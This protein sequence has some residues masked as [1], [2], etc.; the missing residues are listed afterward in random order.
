LFSLCISL[1]VIL[2]NGGMDLSNYKVTWDQDFTT[3]TSLS[4]TAW[5]PGSTWIAHTPYSGD[6]VRFMDPG[7]PYMPFNV[8]NGF[9]TIRMQNISGDLWGGLLA[10]VDPKGNGFSQK[11]G[12]FEFLAKLPPGPRTWPA[13]WLLDVE[14]VVNKSVDLDSEEIDILEQYGSGPSIMHS[15]LHMWNRKNPPLSWGQEKTAIRCDMTSDFHTY[16]ADIQPD[17]ITFYFDRL[18]IGQFPNNAPGYTENFDRE[19]YVLINNAYTGDNVSVTEVQDLQV[20]YARVWQGSGGSANGFDPS[21]STSI[22]WPTAALS[23]QAGDMIK[24]KGITM[25]FTK[26]GIFQLIDQSNNNILWTL[27][28]S[29]T[30]PDATKCYVHFQNDGNFLIDTPV[31]SWASG[32]WGD[33]M[34]SMTLSSQSP[35]LWISSGDCKQL[36]YAH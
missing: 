25:Q 8:G 1:M 19:M 33:N 12:Y 36:W 34:G 31:L 30:C 10:S 3:M 5:G 17:F 21:D 18:A 28:K 7:K 23:M 24:L 4:V 14:S 29:T 13:F 22:T 26:D 16:G 20:K 11:Y 35:Y 15:T 6:W 2:A 32:T 9:L 27:G